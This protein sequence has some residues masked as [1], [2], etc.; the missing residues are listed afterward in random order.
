M[1]Q[2]GAGESE[3]LKTGKSAQCRALYYITLPYKLMQHVS[4]TGN[5]FDLEQSV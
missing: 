2:K 1:N 3:A 4:L 5:D